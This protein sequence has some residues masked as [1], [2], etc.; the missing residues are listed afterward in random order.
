MENMEKKFYIFDVDGTLYS[1]RKMQ[2]A[3]FCKLCFYFIFHLNKLNELIAIKLFRKYREQKEFKDKTTEQTLSAVA[4]KLSM[5]KSHAQKVIDTWMFE[6][7]LHIIKKYAYKDVIEFIKKENA[8]GNCIIIYSDYQPQEK[9]MA[10]G[11]N[12]DFVFCADD[13]NIKELKPSKKAMSYISATT[14]LVVQ[15]TIYVGDRFTKDGISAKIAD[16]KYFDIKDFRRIL[17]GEKN[18]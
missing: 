4:E 17:K 3:M 7:P 15:D 10:L 1:L 11:I 14:K 2:F 6:I 8:S 13:E 16:I 5:E 12:A 9:L 18:D